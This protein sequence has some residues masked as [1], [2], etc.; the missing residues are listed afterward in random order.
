[1]TFAS[2]WNL[3][4]NSTGRS[5]RRRGGKVYRRLKKRLKRK[6]RYQ[7]AYDPALVPPPE[8]ISVHNDP[9]LEE[10]FRWAEEWSVL[11]RVYAGLGRK[12]HVLDIGCGLGRIAFPLRYIIRDGH[13]TGFDVDRRFINFL[14]KSFAPA[15]PSFKFVWAD[16]KN[17]YYNPGGTY[18][19]ANYRFPCEAESVDVAF[20]ASI[21]THM[22]PHNTAHYF[23]ETGR[24]LKPGG[25]CL[26]SFFL[27]DHYRP[28]QPRP[29]MFAK[30]DFSFGYSFD[31]YGDRF[32]ISRPDNPEFM[33]AY[34][35]RLIQEMASAAGLRISGPVLPGLWSGGFDNWVGVQDLVVLE[36][37]SLAR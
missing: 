2:R 31:S 13:Y 5:L 17:T 7:I 6:P 3:W 35:T 28:S 24:A 20:A 14:E 12:S 16:L 34:S 29:F 11:L 33:T 36:K 25:K 26:F 22:V 8:L 27:L 21:F 10:W 23:M 15:Y 4:S 19:T 30:A 1:M 32:A 9:V 18:E 37:P